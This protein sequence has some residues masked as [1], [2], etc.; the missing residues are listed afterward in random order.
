M[1]SR[2]SNLK[3]SKKNIVTRYNFIYFPTYV[4]SHSRRL[5]HVRQRASILI[6][7]VEQ[8]ILYTFFN[9]GALLIGDHHGKSLQCV[10]TLSR[11]DN[12]TEEYKF[13]TKER[14]TTSPRLYLYI[15]QSTSPY[16]PIRINIFFRTVETAL[17]RGIVHHQAPH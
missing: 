6:R 8:M 10:L 5:S 15:F 3:I 4:S 7:V 16:P 17:E 11:V 2:C 9:K 1:L 12:I 14:E 13:S